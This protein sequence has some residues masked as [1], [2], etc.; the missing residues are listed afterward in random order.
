VKFEGSV[1]SVN[2]PSRTLV[3]LVAISAGALVANLYYAQPLID[4]IG[5]EIGIPSHLAGSLTSITQIGYGVGLFFL[6]SLADLVENKRL[7]LINLLLTAVA[8]VCAATARSTVSFFVAS[9][10]VGLCSTSAQILVPFISHLVPDAKRGRI[11]GNVMAGLLAGIM[12]A[13]PVALMISAHL[14]WRAVFLFSAVLMLSIGVILLR[15]MPTRQPPSGKHYLQILRSM[16]G[17]L[18][19]MPILRKRS[20]YQSVMFCVF[21]MFWT[22]AP[23]MLADR[24]GMSEQGIAVFALAGAGGALAAPFAGR[25]ADRGMTRAMTFGAILTLAIT[26]Y[27]AGW[28]TDLNWLAALIVLTVLFD[29]A[30]QTNQITSQR[31]IFSGPQESRGRVNAIYM[32]LNFVGGAL[33]SVLGTLTY[34]SGGWG[35]TALTGGT[36]CVCLLLI[37]LLGDRPPAATTPSRANH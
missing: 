22:A 13:R 7:V 36:M 9:F 8:L 33:G 35:L 37:F 11:V 17:L 18:R 31:M 29:A 24:F 27:G 4:T 3:T 19:E 10:F 2:E 5:R 15:L 34:G 1:T 14:G 16:T 28:A 21:N 6:V 26:S 30:V 32:T 25:L 20:L 12:L 23:I